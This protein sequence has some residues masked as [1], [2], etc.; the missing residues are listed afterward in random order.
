MEEKVNLSEYGEAKWNAKPTLIWLNEFIWIV[1]RIERP[2]L[3]YDAY[4]K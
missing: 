2:V 3:Q 4:L 1:V